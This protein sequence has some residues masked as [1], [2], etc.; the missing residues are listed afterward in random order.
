MGHCGFCC[1][2]GGGSCHCGCTGSHVVPHALPSQG[3]PGVMQR[4]AHQASL[5]CLPNSQNCACSHDP[6]D[7]HGLACTSHLKLSASKH[8]GSSGESYRKA[9]HVVKAWTQP[10]SFKITDQFHCFQCCSTA[11]ECCSLPALDSK[12]D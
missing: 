10:Y 11:S 9:T 8:V 12:V 3:L 1:W 5:Q 2:L 7:Q 4:N 6:P